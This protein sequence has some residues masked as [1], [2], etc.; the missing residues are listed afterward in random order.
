MR[1]L[2][3]PRPALTSIT[4]AV[5][6]VRMKLSPRT[7]VTISFQHPPPR[8]GKVRDRD[9]VTPLTRKISFEHHRTLATTRWQ[10][11]SPSWCVMYGSIVSVSVKCGGSSV[12]SRG[13]WARGL[14]HPPPDT[15]D[16]CPIGTP[17]ATHIIAAIKAP[18][19]AMR[20]SRG[21]N[22]HA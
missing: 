14:H 11:T 7:R 4:D 19:A 13:Q 10:H 20:G 12:V 15:T 8:I 18:S 5:P 9:I 6:M 1:W 3:R 22:N 16:D 17:R 21:G 2:E